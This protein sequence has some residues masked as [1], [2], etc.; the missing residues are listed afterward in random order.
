VGY[1]MWDKLPDSKRSHIPDLISQISNR[2][3]AST[4]V[5]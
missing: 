3:Q 5:M 2:L 4:P 1:A